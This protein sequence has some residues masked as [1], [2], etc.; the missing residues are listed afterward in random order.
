MAAIG[1]EHEHPT[2]GEEVKGETIA[3]ASSSTGDKRPNAFTELM[4]RKQ[5]KS[6]AKVAKES[7]KSTTVGTKVFPGMYGLGAYIDQPEQFEKDRVIDYNDEFV[8]IND[9][10]P[11]SVIHCLI[12]PR[13]K[14][15]T[16]VHPFE[17]FEDA[18]FL[19]ACKTEAERVKKMVGSELRRRYGRF[20][21]QERARIEAME[22]ENPPDEEQLPP[23]RDWTADLLVGIHAGPS[24]AN[25]HVH[26]LSPDRHSA[27]L[28]H[29]KHYN[30]FSTPFLVPLDAFPLAKDDARRH[31]GEGGYLNREFQCWRCQR[32]FGKSMQKLK[33]HLAEEFEQWRSE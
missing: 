29:R 5:A 24:M 26:V 23:G 15:K 6:S 3:D 8:I 25:L 28:K 7:R 14:T 2:S 30:S 9:L 12:L 17:A 31:P 33:E 22:S 11:K 18:Q 20:S 19:E 4:S 21:K 16:L 13:D 10:F 32:S 27:C 1:N